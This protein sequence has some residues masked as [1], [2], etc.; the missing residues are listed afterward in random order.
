MPIPEHIIDEIRQAS[1]VVD[2]V[3]QY[4]PLKK[5]G[6]T[7]KT[8]CPFHQEKTPS[9]NV[10][11]QKQ[12]WHCFG[13]GKGGN[14]YTFLM[15]YDKV[16]FVEAVRTLAQKAGIKIP[17][18]RADFKG[19]Q[20]DLLY[21]ANELAARFFSDNLADPKNRAARD[22]LDK[23]GITKET[24]ELFRLGYA[25]NEWDSL[26]KA[27]GRSGLSL[28]LLQEAG[29][30]VARETGPGFYDRFRHRIIFPFFSLGGRVIGFGGRSLEQ[31]PQA[32]YL[33]SPETPI[34]HKGRGFY[35]FSQTKSAIGDVG[36]AILVEGN[37]DLIVP[38][39]AGFKNILAT[40]GTA[41]TPDQARLLSR[42]ARR[43]VVCYDPDNPGQAAT[44]R[45][46]EPLLEAGLD[47]KAALLPPNLD[48]DAFLR[49][50]GAEEFG[51]L[52]KNAITFVEFMVM[53]AS[54]Q[55]DLSQISEKS[56]LVN[57]LAGLMVKVEDTVSRAHYAKETSDL[58]RV[59]ESLVWDLVRKKQGLSPKQA[60]APGNELPKT[61]WEHE[62]FVL[63][64]KRPQFLKQFWPQLKEGELASDWLSALLQK[65]DQMY[66]ERGLIDPAGLLEQFKDPEQQQSLAM[67]LA[68][69]RQGEDT[70]DDADKDRTV[71]RDYI[72][73][74]KE[75]KLKPRLKELQEKIKVSEKAGDQQ[76]VAQL[77]AQYQELR[78]IY[79][80]KK[81]LIL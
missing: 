53:R 73:K 30:V 44:E 34:Y 14:V 4:L 1:D 20:H 15:E 66:Q 71:L 23:R 74:L 17:E 80:G 35:G 36:F 51:A 3:G 64:V 47:V 6:A 7:Y 69:S 61:D 42:Y 60:A 76:Q 67:I 52:I 38:F 63:L 78:Q 45:A 39:Q 58:C 75:M 41:L 32:K 43:V 48:P 81:R 2:I 72:K 8:L 27:A 5:M 12:I 62:L 19:G 68:R 59:D 10:N 9:F 70:L 77:L 25:P 21:Q 33:N 13:C 37:F 22:Y 56:R 50:R 65:M 18:A 16:S 26:L 49:E 57:D 11:P 46:I 40:A 79:A 24:I 55:R 31:N 29:L 54:M 28:P